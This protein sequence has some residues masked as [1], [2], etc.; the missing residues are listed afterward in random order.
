MVK[1]LIT[2]GLLLGSVVPAWGGEVVW[3]EPTQDQVVATCTTVAKQGNLSF[4]AYIET[5]S[6]AVVSFGSAYGR[7]LFG[8]C[9]SDHGIV[10]GPSTEV[11]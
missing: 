8:K 5:G 10:L 6:R 4:D 3:S 2:A 9:L 11:K 7:F 1:T